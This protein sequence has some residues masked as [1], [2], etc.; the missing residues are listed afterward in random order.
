[1]D[2]GNSDLAFTAATLLTQ[3]IHQNMDGRCSRVGVFY[4]DMKKAFNSVNHNLL[5][6]KLKNNFGLSPFSTYLF[7]KKCVITE[8]TLYLAVAPILRDLSIHKRNP[9]QFLPS[10]NK[11]N[12][13]NNKHILSLFNKLVCI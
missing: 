2:S 1:M 3:L 10:L 8:L 4:I 5:L 11:N 13:P 6:R 7:L 12:L 9:I